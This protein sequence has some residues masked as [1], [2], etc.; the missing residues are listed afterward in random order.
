MYGG[1]VTDDIDRR[2]LTT[3]IND[4]FHDEAVER[5]FFAYVQHGLTIYQVVL[6]KNRISFSDWA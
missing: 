4:T 3:Y 5:P 6:L 2:L 1:H